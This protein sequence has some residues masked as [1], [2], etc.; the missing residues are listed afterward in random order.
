MA[1]F[2]RPKFYLM[3]IPLQLL[4]QIWD[5]R[6]MMQL[7]AHVEQ[8]ETVCRTLHHQS[9]KYLARN[10]DSDVE[11]VGCCYH[12]GQEANGAT[13]PFDFWFRN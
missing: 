10:R 3:S 5:R 6:K 13:F 1:L 12:A 9:Q 4:W 8:A 11:D 2:F 7:K